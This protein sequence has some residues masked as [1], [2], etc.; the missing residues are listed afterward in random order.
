MLVAFCLVAAGAAALN[1][2]VDPNRS[3]G[4]G[5]VG[6]DPNDSWALKHD[7]LEQSAPFNT[8]I[9]GDSRAQRVEPRYVRRRSG[10][11]AFNAS[12][13]GVSMS[14][15]EKTFAAAHARH[16]RSIRRVVLMLGL[17]SFDARA[18]ARPA[19]TARLRRALSLNQTRTSLGLLFERLGL[20]RL[21]GPWRYAGDGREVSTTAW[22][23]KDAAARGGPSPAGLRYTLRAFR[24]HWRDPI[25]PSNSRSFTRLVTRIR[26][27]G[28]T[29]VVVLMPYHPA[30]TS[31]DS[32]LR[33]AHGKVAT[34][35]R[36]LSVSQR[37]RLVDATYLSV[38]GGSPSHFA[39]GVHMSEINARRL[40]DFVIKRAPDAL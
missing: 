20:G 17:E 14:A 25:R 38:F 31:R 5:I 36:R 34:H 22:D 16:P 18:F 26:A 40:I 33:R 2:V 13:T 37:F 23:F 19:G 9:L 32:G 24:H 3:W 30:M 27:A 15:L 4:F 28:A 21:D 39:D 12:V 35:L 8:L 29:T 11:R 6:A 1:I 7:L 10:R